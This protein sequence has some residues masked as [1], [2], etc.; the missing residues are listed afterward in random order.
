MPTYL[1]PRRGISQSEALAESRSYATADEPELI[2]LAFYHSAFRDENGNQVAAYVVNDFE[3]LSATIEAGAPLDAGEAVT[4]QPVPLEIVIP[5]ESEENRDP[6][7]AI[8][9]DNVGRTLTPY[10]RAAAQTQEPVVCIARTYM[11]S[12]TSAPHEMPPLRLEV[13]SASTNGSAVEITAGFGDIT[14]YPFPSVLYTPEGFP[15]LAAAQ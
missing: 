15:G 14:N 3:P 5:E 1:P 2:T 9:V 4:F 11:P 6:Q 7:A 10:F 13:T 8:R 12:D